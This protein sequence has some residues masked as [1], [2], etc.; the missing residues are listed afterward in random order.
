VASNG[1]KTV[2]TG[3]HNNHELSGAQTHTRPTKSIKKIT[4]DGKTDRHKQK[5][6]YRLLKSLRH[7]PHRGKTPQHTF[8]RINPQQNCTNPDGQIQNITQERAENVI[9]Q[10][11]RYTITTEQTSNTFSTLA[12]LTEAVPLTSIYFQE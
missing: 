6:N 11:K 3:Q 12:L 1:I 8:Q 7:G 2:S 5:R 9:T 10:S 4:N